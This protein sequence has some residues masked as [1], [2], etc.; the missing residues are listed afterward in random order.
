MHIRTFCVLLTMLLLATTGIAAAHPPGQIQ[1]VYSEQTGELVLTVTHDVAD[2]A[3]HFVRQ[4]EVRKNGEI[5][6]SERYTSQPS[7]DT[8]TYLYPVP[9]SPGDEVVVTAECNIGGSATARLS[10]PG[11]T[12]TTPTEPGV[13]PLWV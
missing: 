10:M 3:T 1:L 7:A 13:T 11:E 8:F 2:P 4:A 6:I 5:V 9:L 12:V